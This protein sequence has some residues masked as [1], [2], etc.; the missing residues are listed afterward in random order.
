M[1][2]RFRSFR[3]YTTQGIDNFPILSFLRRVLISAPTHT[4]PQRAARGSSLDFFLPSDHYFFLYCCR[5]PT[6]LPSGCFRFQ[7]HFNSPPDSNSPCCA[8]RIQIGLFDF[9]PIRDCL[10]VFLKGRYPE[11][12]GSMIAREHQSNPQEDGD[13]RDTE[14]AHSV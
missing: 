13:T 6:L 9:L 12:G 3:G 8:Q 14:R 5:I 1:T 7:P 11:H 2:L 4:S 10:L